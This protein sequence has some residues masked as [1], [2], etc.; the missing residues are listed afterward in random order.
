[1][2]SQ[3]LDRDLY[4]NNCGGCFSG[5]NTVRIDGK[6]IQVKNLTKGMVLDGGLVVKKLVVSQG[7][8]YYQN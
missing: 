2:V 6:A 8:K 7:G 3:T 5:E 1:M 4:Y